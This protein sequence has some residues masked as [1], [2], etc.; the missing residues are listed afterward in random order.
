MVVLLEGGGVRFL[1]PPLESWE[2]YREKRRN[3]FNIWKKSGRAPLVESSG[4][5]IRGR[6]KEMLWKTFHL[7]QFLLSAS[8][9]CSDTKEHNAS[10]SKDQ[11]HS[12]YSCGIQTL[13]KLWQENTR[14]I[15]RSWEDAHVQA[16]MGLVSL[17]RH[18]A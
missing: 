13:W 2:K 18:N 16:N 15:Q 3:L 10:G 12:R 17:N 4:G 11:L 7:Q 14:H 8:I 1:S 5:E 6:N 9:A